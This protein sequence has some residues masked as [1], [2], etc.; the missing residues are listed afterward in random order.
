MSG[1]WIIAPVILPAMLA[2]L[3]ALAMRHDLVLQRVFA[4]AG[5]L[6]LLGIAVGLTATAFTGEIAVY[7]LGDWP[8]PFGIVLVLDRLAALM[9]LL[10][11]ILGVT[12]TLHAIGTGWDRRGWHFHALLMF[13]TMGSTGRS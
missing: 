4:L 12:V 5:S 10:T 7:E 3:M 11:A 1:H 13:Q 6:S 8:A 2:P 9:L